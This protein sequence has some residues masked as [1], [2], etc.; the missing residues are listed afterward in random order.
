MSNNINFKHKDINNTILNTPNS[1]NNSI[2][3]FI[4]LM[5]LEHEYINKNLS[6]I[7]MKLVIKYILF[8]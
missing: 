7:I 3:L 1:P 4:T 2:F 6:Y 5:K 8:F